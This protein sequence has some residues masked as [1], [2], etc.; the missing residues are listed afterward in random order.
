MPRP[1][2]ARPELPGP[3][4]PESV[5]RRRP[6]E[7]V[8]RPVALPASARSGPPSRAPASRAPPT[9]ALPPPSARPSPPAPPGTDSGDP[10]VRGPVHCG[11]GPRRRHR[12]RP[13]RPVQ[14]PGQTPAPGLPGPGTEPA[15]TPD[16]PRDQ[17]GGAD[18]PGGAGQGRFGSG[19]AGEQAQRGGLVRPGPDPRAVRAG[20]DRGS[21]RHPY[22]AVD[23][24]QSG[25][26]E[27]GPEDR[28]SPGGPRGGGLRNQLG[29]ALRQGE[30][31][32]PARLR[33]LQQTV[34]AAGD[35]RRHLAGRR[36][37]LQ[38]QRRGLRRP[39]RHQEA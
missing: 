32:D 14:R 31:A 22:R 17:G 6:A 33:G 35:L 7:V 37:R 36:P 34:T 2:R 26:A 28:G 9:R 21:R 11:R 25:Q 24:P 27:A 29:G 12:L 18:P 39:D 13:G 30:T 8:T 10:G 23:L 16:D 1:T 19:P 4:L 38:R 20:P 15:A 3:R 5:L